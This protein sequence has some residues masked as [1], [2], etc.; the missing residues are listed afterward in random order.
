MLGGVEVLN[1]QEIGKTN[2]P[3]QKKEIAIRS[4]SRDHSPVRMTNTHQRLEIRQTKSM[5][6]KRMLDKRTMKRMN[7]R[8]QQIQKRQQMIRQREA[9]RRR[10]MQQ[11]QQRMNR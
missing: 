5:M 10:M 3:S 2:I 8:R 9:V 4:N 11:R 1:A 6:Y 7:P